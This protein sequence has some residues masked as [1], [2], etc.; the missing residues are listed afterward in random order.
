MKLQQQR[1]G[2]GRAGTDAGSSER[3]ITLVT[4]EILVNNTDYDLFIFEK[5]GDQLACLGAGEAFE[6]PY[7]VTV[8]FDANVQYT[9]RAY[10]N[11]G[12][13]RN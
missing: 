13:R 1:T 12:Y 9:F 5:G 11:S 7:R 10:L 6:A 2:R 4:A 3:A 8:T